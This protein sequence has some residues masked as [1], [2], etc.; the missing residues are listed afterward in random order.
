LKVAALA[1]V[2]NGE[3]RTD[4]ALGARELSTP[5]IHFPTRRACDDARFNMRRY[6]ALA[7][8]R[9]LQNVLTVVTEGDFPVL[10]KLINS[11]E[12]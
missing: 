8:S 2:G 12:A 5:S 3:G 1:S 9:K 7:L 4:E 11:S 10:F 6:V